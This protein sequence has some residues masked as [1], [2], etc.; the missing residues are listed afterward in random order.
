VFDQ[1]MTDTLSLRKWD[2]RVFERIR[3]CV[4]GKGGILIEDVRLPI[5]SGD[6]LTRDLPNGLREEFIVDDP[7]FNGG[8]GDITAHFQV[9]VRRASQEKRSPAT[10]QNVFYGPVGGVAQNSKHFSQTV[11]VGIPSQDLARLVT[12]LTTH[13]NELNLD[14][15]RK[16]RTEAQLAALK[17]ELAGDPDPAIVRQAGRTLRNVIEGAIG[18]LL[19]TAAQ[20]DIWRW[21]HE[22]LAKF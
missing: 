18:S 5:E 11:S 4:G 10:V 17:V 1:L 8:L 3:A 22:A 15:Q 16:K 6:R 19:A 21:I 7:G 14:A 2:G 12:E 13:L 20:P 9:K